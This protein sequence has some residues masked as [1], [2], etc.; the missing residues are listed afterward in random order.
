MTPT[1]PTDATRINPNA[2]DNLLKSLM[3]DSLNVDKSL[4]MLT[5]IGAG[6]RKY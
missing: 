5:N 4:Q 3:L 6:W 2:V 1:V